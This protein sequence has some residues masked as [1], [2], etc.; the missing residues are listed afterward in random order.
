MSSTNLSRLRSSNNNPTTSVGTPSTTTSNEDDTATP[1]SCQS[2][3]STNH[4][5][6][7][8]TAAASSNNNDYADYLAGLYDFFQPK[9]IYLDPYPIGLVIHIGTAY[10]YHYIITRVV[11]ESTAVESTYI[12]TS[13]E[14]GKEYHVNGEDVNVPHGVLFCC[15]QEI[16]RLQNRI[17][18][19]AGVVWPPR[20]RKPQPTPLSDVTSSNVVT[21]HHRLLKRR[22]HHPPQQTP[23]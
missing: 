10:G 15:V 7:N 6:N 12:V 17:M 20:R 4:D 21:I 19:D 9:C 16:N 18:A 14:D 13:V 11:S 23:L 5:Y 2:A 22:I 8:N 3:L 1:P